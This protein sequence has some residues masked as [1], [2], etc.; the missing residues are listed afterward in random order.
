M[1]SYI[2]PI[3]TV[4]DIEANYTNLEDEQPTDGSGVEVVVF[5]RPRRALENYVIYKGSSITSS[6]Q[7]IVLNV[8]KIQDVDELVQ[9]PERTV[10][11]VLT[12]TTMLTTDHIYWKL[13]TDITTTE[14]ETITERRTAPTSPITVK[15][16]QS[17]MSPV[18][19]IIPFGGKRTKRRKKK[20]KS[21]RKK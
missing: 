12:L 15:G 9:L 13:Y 2:M 6:G 8:T 21:R 19:V 1:V 17:P 4:E 7:H 20:R 14:P 18:S 11:T 5:K 3:L 10:N 16:P